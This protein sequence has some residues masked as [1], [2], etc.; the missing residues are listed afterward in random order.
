M[1]I[2]AAVDGEGVILADDILCAKEFET[3]ALIKLDDRI[4]RCAWYCAAHGEA[5]FSDPTLGIF[6]GW[7]RK[8]AP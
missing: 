2:D 8:Q 6:L 5:A 4:L 7:L 3:G 1:T